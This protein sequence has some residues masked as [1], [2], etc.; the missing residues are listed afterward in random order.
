MQ[1]AG[2]ASYVVAKWE[3]PAP[4]G[5]KPWPTSSEKVTLLTE[6]EM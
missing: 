1:E 2:W 6:Q 4:V 5:N 3:V